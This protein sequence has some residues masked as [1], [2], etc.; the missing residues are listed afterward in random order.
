MFNDIMS[1]K[2]QA[3]HHRHIVV[4]IFIELDLLRVRD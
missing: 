2:Q 4:V 1:I 3:Q